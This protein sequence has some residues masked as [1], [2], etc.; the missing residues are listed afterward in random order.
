MKLFVYVAFNSYLECTGNPRF[1]SHSPE[2]F[3]TSFKRFLL[4]GKLEEVASFENVSW[5]QIGTYD[6]ETMKFES[7]KEPLFLLRCDEALDKRK[8]KM[9][10]I[11]KAKEIAEEN[12]DE[13]EA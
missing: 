5:Y 3:A 6:D 1:E 4:T 12:E 11:E 8:V 10:L 7:L 13:S 2:S 9:Q